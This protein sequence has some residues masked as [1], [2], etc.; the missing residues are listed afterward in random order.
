MAEEA[1]Q[2]RGLV[3]LSEYVPLYEDKL[4]YFKLGSAQSPSLLS[5][6]YASILWFM[7]CE[8]VKIHT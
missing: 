2:N 6:T 3:K 1:I 8:H 7:V 4:H 5:N